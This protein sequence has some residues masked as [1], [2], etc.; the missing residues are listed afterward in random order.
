M[1]SR[2]NL[3]FKLKY[4]H[5]C[6]CIKNLAIMNIIKQIFYTYFGTFLAFIRILLAAWNQSNSNIIK[7]QQRNRKLFDHLDMSFKSPSGKHAMWAL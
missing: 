3:K 7:K 2:P 6:I 4:M 1:F 5:V